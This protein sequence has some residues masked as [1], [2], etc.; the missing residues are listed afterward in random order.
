VETWARALAGLEPDLLL[1]PALVS[2]AW[3][4]SWL[5]AEFH[6]QVPRAP[7]IVGGRGVS[8]VETQELLLRAGWAD[9]IVPGESEETL[10]ALVDEL[11]SGVPISAARARGLVAMS[12]GR[13]ITVPDGSPRADLDALP[14]PDYAG[15]PFPG[16]SLRYYSDTGRDFHDAVSIGGSRWCPRHCA[17]CYE[18]IYPKNYRLRSVGSVLDEIER[19]QAIFGTNRLFFCDS[20]MNASPQWLDEL[21]RGM[22]RL[23][24]APDVIFAH[25]EPRRITRQLLDRM[26]A[27][28]FRKLNFGIES[29]D[30]RTLARM[31]RSTTAAETEEAVVQ[32][33][34]AG[35]SLGVN[36]IANYPGESQEEFDSTLSRAQGL[37]DR[38]RAVAEK[39]GAGVRFMV[40]QARV[41]P[42][43]SL[44]LN[45]PAFGL[46]I[47]RRAVVVPRALSPLAPLIERL[48]LRWDSGLP[49]PERRR[50]F[51]IMRPFI[52][53]LSIPTRDAPARPLA[54]TRTAVDFSRV[55][56]ALLPLLCEPPVARRRAAG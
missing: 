56:R 52:E 40:S 14:A 28:G 11:A 23:P 16:A 30:D 33:V 39:T 26:R 35:I 18:S 53:A 36:L 55:P 54:D 29:L 44:F 6:T 45:A 46:L 17:Y 21:S 37:A 3:I 25:C 10:P 22:A 1:L 12:E 31:Q 34:K 20:T 41:D 5:S 38:L 49:T 7:R 4:V 19:Q 43:S 8:Y 42:H 47:S 24:F 13:V 50:R 9:G 32:A 15:L 48:A 2:N 51:G 27:G